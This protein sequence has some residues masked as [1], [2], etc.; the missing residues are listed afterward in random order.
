MSKSLYR[1]D[2]E[3][4]ASPRHRQTV[5]RHDGGREVRRN[6]QGP[7]K[8]NQKPRQETMRKK[9]MNS[10]TP[11]TDIARSPQFGGLLGSQAVPRPT[12]ERSSVAW[13][14]L[15]KLALDGNNSAAAALCEW[16]YQRRVASELQSSAIQTIQAFAIRP[17]GGWDD[18][19]PPIDSLASTA[20]QAWIRFCAPALNREKLEADG[21]AAVP[22]TAVIYSA[23]A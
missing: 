23:N 15:K 22:V 18:D 6:V 2:S 20:E 9:M 13:Q 4:N 7:Q 21:F 5:G 17:P 14:W 1:H 10:D 12:R 8:G 11:K 3:R 16:E 19:L